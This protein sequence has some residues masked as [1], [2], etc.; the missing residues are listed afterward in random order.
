MRQTLH[1][2]VCKQR[3]TSPFLEKS[4]HIPY[5]FNTTFLKS[6]ALPDNNCLLRELKNHGNMLGNRYSILII[7]LVNA[8]NVHPEILACN[9]PTQFLFHKF[10]FLL[11]NQ[12]PLIESPDI[13]PFSLPPYM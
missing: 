11:G 3:P 6:G 12:K 5:S 8:Q 7:V 2:P 4:I 1:V 13:V 9:H 10:S